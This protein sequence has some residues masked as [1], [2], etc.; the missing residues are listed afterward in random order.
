MEQTSTILV[1]ILVE[2][3]LY[4]CTT[5]TQGYMI[6]RRVSCME[7]GDTQPSETLYSLTPSFC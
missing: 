1:N 4:L 7:N 3:V 5:N 6:S 2:V